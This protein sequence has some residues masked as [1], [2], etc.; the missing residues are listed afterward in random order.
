MMTRFKALSISQK[1]T[2]FVTPILLIIK[3]TESY[4]PKLIFGSDLVNTPFEWLYTTFIFIILTALIIVNRERLRDLF[5]DKVFLIIY[6]LSGVLYALYYWGTIVG[7]V[8][9][10]IMFILFE[11]LR[12]GSLRFGEIDPFLFWPAMILGIVPILLLL[13]YISPSLLFQNMAIDTKMTLWKIASLL[14]I[15]L[16][17]EM[18]FRSLL[19]SSLLQLGLQNSQIFVVQLLLFGVYQ[20]KFT[21]YYWAM[22]IPFLIGAWLGI[23]VWRSKSLTPGA[24][25]Y[26]LGV[27]LLQFSS[28]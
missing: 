2:L 17:G 14:W 12:R 21:N 3:T 26:F 24:I 7:I 15:V 18:V 23:L 4:W 9:G 16:Y 13:A 10:V 25:A 1:I 6:I 8:V 11:F 5:I 19:W 20:V 22:L 27:L 28:R